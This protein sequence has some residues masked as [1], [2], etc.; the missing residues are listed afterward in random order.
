MW[1]AATHSAIWL[2]VL[3]AVP[4]GTPPWPPPMSYAFL[5]AATSAWNCS[6]VTAES[7]PLQPPVD[8]TAVPLASSSE[9]ADC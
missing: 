1:F 8:I 3:S 5:P 4:P 2:L 7:V 6:R 9:A